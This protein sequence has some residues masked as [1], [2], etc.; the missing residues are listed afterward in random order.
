[1]FYDQVQDEND[2]VLFKLKF[3]PDPRKKQVKHQQLN[4]QID[5]SSIIL[6]VSDHDQQLSPQ[7]LPNFSSTA[8]EAP[9]QILDTKKNKTH[10]KN[11]FNTTMKISEINQISAI[12]SM[13]HQEVI[14]ENPG[15]T[16]LIL[17]G[18]GLS[19][20]NSKFR[21]ELKDLNTA[22]NKGQNQ[23]QSPS[24]GEVYNINIS[25]DD[26]ESIINLL[27]DY[28]TLKLGNGREMKIPRLNL[29]ALPNIFPPQ[30][31]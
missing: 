18:G 1:M 8:N 9:K 13:E 14:R 16:E 22:L 19:S 10:Q 28:V 6:A 25:R 11:L 2:P 4:E 15:E 23:E 26:A 5:L 29:A 7:K 31:H 24:T 12:K 27:K 20:A 17:G 21:D 3:Q 30:I